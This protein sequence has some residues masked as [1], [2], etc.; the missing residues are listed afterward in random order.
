MK[1]EVIQDFL[2]LPGIA[3]VALMDGRSRP[4][5][6]GVD[7]NLN[8]QQKEALAQGIQQVV[9]TTPADF[10]FFEFQFAGHQIYL[11]KLDH[12]IILLVLTDHRLVRADY[13]NVIASLQQELTADLSN[14]IATFRL[15]A[16]T[17]SLSSQNYWNQTT[18]ASPSRVA[19][20]SGQDATARAPTA[21]AAPAPEAS[22]LADSTTS[23]ALDQTSDEPVNLQ[24]VLAALN[25]LS[26]YAAQYLG[27]TVVTNTWKSSRPPVEWLNQ[28]Q[29]DR[30]A[31]I[32]FLSSDV[33]APSQELNPE[34]HQWVQE[35]TVAFI[36][37]CGR[38]IRGFP[39]TVTQK[40]L[41]SQQQTLLL[42]KTFEQL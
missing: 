1:R 39:R 22:N 26:Q 37:R 4:Y 42:P 21:V 19:D 3:G 35:W 10:E 11:Y 25:Q 28:F 13:G 8:F 31:K 32:V 27:K 23:S 15:L 6:F 5:F 17:I 9:E 41:D 34:Q 2:N 20:A 36:Q 14:A 38:I 33:A 18:D 30:S 16:G 40:V 29:V 24:A 7:Q 12:G